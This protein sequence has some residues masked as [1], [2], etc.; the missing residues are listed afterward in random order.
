MLHPCSNPYTLSRR[1]LSRPSRPRASRPTSAMASAIPMTPTV[2]IHAS[3]RR[4]I[5]LRQ[6]MH[7]DTPPPPGLTLR[8]HLEVI[9]A[10]LRLARR[11]CLLPPRLELLLSAHAQEIS[12]SAP[13]PEAGPTCDLPNLAPFACRGAVA[14]VS[15]SLTPIT[16][17]RGRLQH[18]SFLEN[19]VG[20]FVSSLECE[21]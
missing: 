19:H 8:S 16:F 1:G 5:A 2:S 17:S 18:L 3:Y 13:P 6:P 11:L 14:R 4:R 20:T 9:A 7:P 10:A 21:G 12:A 15:A